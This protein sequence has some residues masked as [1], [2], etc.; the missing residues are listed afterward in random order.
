VI[1]ASRAAARRRVRGA[2]LSLALLVIPGSAL[3]QDPPR[4][5]RDTLP[6]PRDTLAPDT[7]PDIDQQP[8]TALVPAVVFPAMPLAPRISAAGTRWVWDRETLLRS[9][10]VSLIDL[11]ERV[12]GITS[13][14]AGTFVQPEVASA[15]GGTAGRIRVVLD[16]YVLDPLAGSTFDLSQ[17][18]LGH[19]REVRVERR[20]GLLD[21]IL[22]TDHPEEGQPLTRVEAGI[23]VPAANLFRGLF[24]VPDVIIGPLGLAIERLD[25]DGVGRAQPAG[26]FGGWAKW[27]WTDGERGLQLEW[28]RGTLRREPS[29]PWVVERLRQDIVL[30]GRT[31]LAR[32]LVAELF[33]GR[34]EIDQAEPAADD[35]EPDITTERVSY[36]AGA[37][38]GLELPAALI[39][40]SIRYPQAA[41][42]MDDVAGRAAPAAPGPQMH[43][44]P[45]KKTL[46][47]SAPE[48]HHYLVPW[49]LSRSGRRRGPW[50]LSPTI[51]GLN[52]SICQG[53]GPV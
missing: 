53:L 38:A 5:Q 46:C 21:I 40:A 45:L 44:Q 16:G 12:P 19:L 2:L 25:T 22:T 50:R 24:L 20:L 36:Q 7:L 10:H 23:G 15:F 28:M 11:L 51:F 6:V 9:A 42:A 26:L 35:T 4:P 18:A 52:F 33:A 29:S 48:Q 1:A 41:D 14:R 31:R 37:R 34:S 43:A 47:L 30:R 13:F 17:I 8:D 49:T 3:A 39:N 32:G 27:S